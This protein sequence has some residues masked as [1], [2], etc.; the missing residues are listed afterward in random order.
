MLLLRNHCGV[1]FSL[2][3]SNTIRRR[4]ARRMVLSKHRTFAEYAGFLKG[5]ATELDTLFRTC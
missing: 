1:D 3:K 4:I 2:Y 5:N